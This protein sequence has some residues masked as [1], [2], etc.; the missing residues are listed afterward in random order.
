MLKKIIGYKETNGL[1]FQKDVA[2]VKGNLGL[3]QDI[4]RNLAVKIEKIICDISHDYTEE[5]HKPY[6]HEIILIL[7]NGLKSCLTFLNKNAEEYEVLINKII[8]S[9]R[10]KVIPGNLANEQRQSVYENKIMPL[11]ALKSGLDSYKDDPFT[12]IKNAVHK[13]GGIKLNTETIKNIKQTMKFIS[14][15]KREKSFLLG[16]SFNEDANNDIPR[17]MAEEL[18]E[19]SRD[20]FAFRL[21]ERYFDILIKN[22]PRIIERLA[23]KKILEEYLEL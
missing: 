5:E 2:K 14:A 8:K 21:V 19:I 6:I 16:Y 23:D 7:K 3:E 10:E 9:E 17:N 18:D 1:D 12:S 20:T 22:A 11:R 4:Y 13:V 15:L